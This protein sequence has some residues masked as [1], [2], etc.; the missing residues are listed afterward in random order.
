MGNR[1][2]PWGCL[3]RSV[4][5]QMERHTIASSVSSLCSECHLPMECS[6]VHKTDFYFNCFKANT[7]SFCMTRLDR[8]MD[9]FYPIFLLQVKKK[10]NCGKV[11]FNLQSRV[12]SV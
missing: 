1:M 6:L 9:H 5:E 4:H 7:I 8:T 10:I 3:L 2:L 12:K 11:P